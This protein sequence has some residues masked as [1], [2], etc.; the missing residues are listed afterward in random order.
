MKTEPLRDGQYDEWMNRKWRP[1]M[2]YTYMITCVTDFILFPICWSIFQA[3]LDKDVTPWEPLTLQGAGLFH[4]AMGAV[5]GVAAWSRGKEKIAGVSNYN[6]YSSYTYNRD[7]DDYREYNH[8][9]R[10][11]RHFKRPD[12]RKKPFQEEFPEL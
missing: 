7:Y 6:P 4:L 3:Y 9:D 8:D 1:L 11:P 12:I 2:G 10:R 5:L